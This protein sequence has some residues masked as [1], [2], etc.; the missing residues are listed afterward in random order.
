MQHRT[1]HI[2]ASARRA[3]TLVEILVVVA[4]IATMTALLVA[5]FG[6][7]F[8]VA[9][10]K[11]TLATIKKI[12]LAINERVNAL[13]MAIEK[14]ELRDTIDTLQ[15]T[16][17]SRAAAVTEVRKDQMKKMFPQ[18][19]AEAGVAPP[20]ANTPSAADNAECLYWAVTSGI[21]H[22][23]ASVGQDSYDSSE[24]ADTDKDGLL[25]FVDGWGN[26]LRFY[27][28]PTR[29]LRPNYDTSAAI[30]DPV[31]TGA[32]K[33][34]AVLVMPSLSDDVLGSDP[35]APLEKLLYSRY[36]G[37]LGNYEARYH[38]PA[39]YHAPL[40]ISAGPDQV[41]GLNEPT[42]TTDYGYLAKP[43]PAVLSASDPGNSPLA[44]DISNHQSMD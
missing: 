37:N 32:R 2:T 28:W 21:V 41:L 8:G 33:D 9:R 14:G 1:H 40:V 25:E 39:T 44:D 12:N 11:A 5:T 20:S 6:G 43:T 27:R 23:A 13:E 24:V 35:D 3:F 31:N 30:G 26:P 16:G 22:G 7:A 29:L 36:S 17:Y 18:T 19:W 42:D 15:K 4:I 34:I 38:T 10:E